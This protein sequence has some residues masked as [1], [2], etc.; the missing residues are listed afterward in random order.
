MINLFTFKILKE[1]AINGIRTGDKIV[2]SDLDNDNLLKER[3]L[4]LISHNF[5]KSVHIGYLESV[6]FS[7]GSFLPT[8]T[9]LNNDLGESSYFDLIDIELFKVLLDR[10]PGKLPVAPFQI[11]SQLSQ[12]PSAF[13]SPPKRDAVHPQN[14]LKLTFPSDAEQL[15]LNLKDNIFFRDNKVNYQKAID[16]FIREFELPPVIG[17]FADMEVRNLKRID[18]KRDYNF[19]GAGT[20]TEFDELL[21]ELMKSEPVLDFLNSRERKFRVFMK[22]SELIDL[23][24]HQG[25]AEFDGVPHDDDVIILFFYEIRDDLRNL[26]RLTLFLFEEYKK[27]YFPKM[28]KSLFVSL[29]EEKCGLD[30]KGL[31]AIYQRLMTL[32]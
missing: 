19:F 31:K 20:L 21:A 28:T 11:F 15:S 29:F 26:S 5:S 23:Y 17:Y 14:Q 22:A 7:D 4:A 6:D 8:V 30:W 13:S 32:R 18:L 16:L 27:I 9:K 25:I 2:V 3:D 10:K 1:Y 12:D 24:R